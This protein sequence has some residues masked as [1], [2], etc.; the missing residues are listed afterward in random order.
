MKFNITRNKKYKDDLKNFINEN[1]GLNVY[2]IKAASRGV[3]GETW[4]ISS[5]KENYF[6][7]IS[8]YST[9]KK[10]FINGINTLNVLNKNKIK[11]INKI[12]KTKNNENYAIFGDGILAIYDFVEGKIDYSYPYDKIM[13]LLLPIYKIDNL[14]GLFTEDFNVDKIINDTKNSIELAQEYEELSIVLNKYHNRISEYIERLKYYNSVIDKNRKMVITHGDACVN[15][16]VS[17]NSE[18]L[19]DFDDTLV[20]PIERDCWFFIDS[21]KKI[22]DINVYLKESGI[23]YCLSNDLLA[24]YAYESSLIYVNNAI[25]KYDETK[26]KDILE[27]IEEILN[28]WVRKKIESINF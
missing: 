10:A 3:D 14:E 12:I 16:M 22:D 24:F 28:G 18:C 11:H 25:K 15:V 6:A 7:K 20:A 1:Y 19:I 8:Y 5:E 26:S 9:H 4:I 23:D 2:K 27:E 13:K 17:G 21:N